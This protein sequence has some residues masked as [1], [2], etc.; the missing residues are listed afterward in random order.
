MRRYQRPF[1]PTA[2]YE[3]ERRVSLSLAH[4]TSRMRSS[5]ENISTMQNELSANVAQNYDNILLAREEN[6]VIADNLRAAVS[7]FNKLSDRLSTLEDKVDH[8]KQAMDAIMKGNKFSEVQLATQQRQWSSQGLQMERNMSRLEE[9]VI[10]LKQTADANN[11]K[12]AKTDDK[13]EELLQQLTKQNHTMDAGIQDLRQM[14][15]EIEKNTKKNTK[16]VL[17]EIEHKIEVEEQKRRSKFTSVVER[18]QVLQSVVNDLKKREVN[19]M[20]SYAK[21]MEEKD[22]E[23]KNELNNLFTKISTHINNNQTQIQQ[24]S[25]SAKDKTVI[26]ELRKKVLFLEQQLAMEKEARLEGMDKLEDETTRH[27]KKVFNDIIAE[28]DKL[29]SS[30]QNTH[31]KNDMNTVLEE[32]KQEIKAN[33]Q[34]INRVLR[35]EITAR[36][37]QAQK[38]STSIQGVQRHSSQTIT[39]LQEAMQ[40]MKTYVDKEIGTK[41]VSP[42]GCENDAILAMEKRLL[43]LEQKLT[44]HQAS[45]KGNANT[46]T[47]DE[48]EEYF[49]KRKMTAT[50]LRRSSVSRGQIDH[51][52]KSIEE[53]KSS[54]R[55]AELKMS[56][57]KRKTSRSM[58]QERKKRNKFVE[59]INSR[60]LAGERLKIFIKSFGAHHMKYLMKG[61]EEQKPGLNVWG[62]YQ[63]WRMHE[64]KKTW[65]RL[66]NREPVSMSMKEYRKIVREEKINEK[67]EAKKK[68]KKRRMSTFIVESFSESSE[69]ESVIEEQQEEDD[70]EEE[71]QEVENEKEE[72]SETDDSAKE[73]EENQE[74]SDEEEGQV[75]KNNR[76]VRRAS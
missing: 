15:H 28:L 49:M 51:I 17:Q 44:N 45:D 38:F 57:F 48:K 71:E 23:Y 43:N 7:F 61:D 70:K 11:K 25:T 56:K 46:I 9:E 36:K 69:E 42:A 75:T 27:F 65:L 73:K 47:V 74:Y 53:L 30:L 14:S 13:I 3:D 68:E 21:L 40:E 62:V 8:N 59:F 20:Q 58:L 5:L 76:N 6:M 32:M 24:T 18:V 12:I 41:S 31:S 55:N 10:R 63:A 54:M 2:G 33:K 22:H 39:V 72:E 16:T 29:N 60:L 66:I 37:S 52:E 4:D 64:Y 19:G 26:H 35:A 34:V 1:P 67:V 50:I